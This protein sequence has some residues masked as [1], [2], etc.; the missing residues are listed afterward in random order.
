LSELD[1]EAHQKLKFAFS[2]A[3][4]EA[5]WYFTGNLPRNGPSKRLDRFPIE[6]SAMNRRLLAYLTAEAG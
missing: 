1:P 3:R 6:P 4:Q 2:K 5:R